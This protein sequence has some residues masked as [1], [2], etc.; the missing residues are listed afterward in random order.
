MHNGKK[1]NGASKIVLGNQIFRKI[2]FRCAL[3]ET[4]P[5]SITIFIL[6]LSVGLKPGCL[7]ARCIGETFRHALQKYKYLNLTFS[8]LGY[9]SLFVRMRSLG[10]RHSGHYF[11]TML[12]LSLDLMFNKWAISSLLVHSLTHTHTHTHT[13][14]QTGSLQ[15][16][17]AVIVLEGE[18]WL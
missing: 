8:T 1:K 4:G 11:F 5:Q 14:T 12:S 13:H 3:N 2:T 18:I 7:C 9:F 15:C 16:W 10:A 6:A 17:L